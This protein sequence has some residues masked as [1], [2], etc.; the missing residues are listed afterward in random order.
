MKKHAVIV[1]VAALAAVAPGRIIHVPG[2]YPTIQAGIDAA[3]S[4]DV[5]MVAA[6]TYPEEILLKAGVIVQGAGEG[7]SMIDGGDDPGDVVRAIGSS[8]TRDTKL[9]GF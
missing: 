8:I 5:V 2:E 9:R 1:L 4:G 7:L 3:V 6:G